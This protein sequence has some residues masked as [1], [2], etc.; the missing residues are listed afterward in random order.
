MV[1]RLRQGGTAAKQ[2]DPLDTA[3][4]P[5]AAPVAPAAPAAQAAPA[6]PAVPASHHPITGHEDFD[7]AWEYTE[8][9]LAPPPNDSFSLP[10][11]WFTDGVSNDP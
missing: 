8:G 1:P 2:P 4:P 3:T 7:V 5:P 11:P 10:P 6:A 9:G